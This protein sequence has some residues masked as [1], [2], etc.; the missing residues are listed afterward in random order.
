M[1]SQRGIATGRP[2]AWLLILASTGRCHTL[3]PFRTSV[4]LSKVDKAIHRIDGYV[5]DVGDAQLVFDSLIF[6]IW[7]SSEGICV[8]ALT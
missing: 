6:E 2:S 5:I 3:L 4:P 1:G 8:G 7:R